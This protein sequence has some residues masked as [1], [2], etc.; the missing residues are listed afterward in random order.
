IRICKTCKTVTRSTPSTSA[1][2]M[3]P[4]WTAGWAVRAQASWV[5]GSLRC[6][7]FTGGRVEHLPV[8]GSLFRG[9]GTALKEGADRFPL[10]QSMGPAAKARA[11]P[12]GSETD[13]PKESGREVP[14]RHGAGV[15]VAGHL[16]A[17]AVR[18][19]S[20]HAAAGHHHAVTKRP[21]VPAGVGVHL[22]RAA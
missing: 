14:G 12:R 11:L 3:P 6:R 13:P 19:P 4:C 18:A 2:F 5:P 9:S 8:F 21:V 7:S 10:G 17:G 15:G 20:L 22:G 16:V 1:R